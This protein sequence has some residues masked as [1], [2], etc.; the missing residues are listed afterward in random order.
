MQMGPAKCR[1]H[2]VGVVLWYAQRTE[3]VAPASNGVKVVCI[4]DVMRVAVGRS[5][6]FLTGHTSVR[7]VTVHIPYVLEL[8]E[9]AL[10]ALPA[11]VREMNA[12]VAVTDVV[13]VGMIVN[14]LVVRMYVSKT[15][16][17][18]NTALSA[19]GVSAPRHVRVAIP[20]VRAL[21]APTLVHVKM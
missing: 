17:V 8:A 16:P 1:V 21:H 3:P 4:V 7:F 10:N 13:V 6:V 18:G 11:C 15:V 20:V 12:P 5:V 9:N 19:M 2:V 14:V